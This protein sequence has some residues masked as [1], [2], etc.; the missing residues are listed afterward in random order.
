MLTA[1]ENASRPYMPDEYVRIGRS[2]NSLELGELHDL[3]VLLR[4]LLAAQPGG[5]PAQDDVLDG[6]SGR[7]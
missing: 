4:E 2:M 7:G 1:T 3:V 6:R 5:Q